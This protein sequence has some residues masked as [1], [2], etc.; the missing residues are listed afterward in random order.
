[1]AIIHVCCGGR[2]WR[3]SEEA[4]GVS[5]AEPNNDQI[6]GHLLDRLIVTIVG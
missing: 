1:M 4:F 6:H 2:D 5:S 3:E